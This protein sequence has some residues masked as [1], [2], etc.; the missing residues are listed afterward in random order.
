MWV[1]VVDRVDVGL[2]C[3]RDT[4]LIDRVPSDVLPI[5]LL[6]HL[7]DVA[8]WRIV[9]GST[10]IFAVHMP[11]T[12]VVDDVLPNS[13]QVVID[14]VA[15][16]DWLAGRIVQSALRDDVPGAQCTVTPGHVLHADIPA[17][18]S[19]GHAAVANYL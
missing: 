17:I 4:L 16:P 12:R 13:I 15:L 11:A 18:V 10:V 7:P 1:T 14:N 19:T 9:A 5:V 6:E 8:R 2:L 3:D